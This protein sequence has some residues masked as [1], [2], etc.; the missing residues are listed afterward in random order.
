MLGSSTSLTVSATNKDIAQNTSTKHTKHTSLVGNRCY[1]FARLRRLSE[2]LKVE[3]VPASQPWS[4]Q[5]ALPAETVAATIL[6][7]PTI[8]F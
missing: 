4:C 1:A 3:A 6:S 7:P 2:T 8:R 5:R